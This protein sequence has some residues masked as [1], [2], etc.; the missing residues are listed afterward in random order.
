MIS[1]LVMTRSSAPFGSRVARGA[2]AHAVA[3][4]LAAAE[5]DLVAVDGE[6]L[7]DF[8]DQFGIGQPDAVAGGGSVEIGIDAARNAEAHRLPFPWWPE[9]HARAGELHQFDLF[10]LARLE[11]H[12]G[13]GG[14]IQPHAAALVA[15]E[16]QRVVHFEEMIVAADLNGAVA[17]CAGRP[18]VRVRAAGVGLDRLA[19]SRKYSP[20]FIASSSLNRVVY[21][22][23]LGAVRERRFH[24]HLV[25]HFRDALHDVGAGQDWAPSV[26]ISA[27]VLPSRALQ[28]F[29]G[30]NRDGFRIV[31]LQPARTPFARDFG[32]ATKIRSRSCSRGVRCTAFLLSKFSAEAWRRGHK[33]IVSRLPRSRSSCPPATGRSGPARA[34]PLRLFAATAISSFA[35]LCCS[36]SAAITGSM[37]A[38]PSWQR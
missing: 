29:G 23:Q 14:D 7:F 16:M 28:D 6:V 32:A 3:N 30:E 1:A 34:A 26:M 2:L 38:A 37:R 25:D 27:T 8:D 33:E 24:L 20:G 11:A 21:G 9:D 12:G 10:L 13:P 19:S 15:I 35:T 18:R 4:D 31:Q 17:R 36:A 5:G 22:D